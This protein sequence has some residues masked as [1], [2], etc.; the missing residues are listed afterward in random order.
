MTVL[1]PIVHTRHLFDRCPSMRTTCSMVTIVYHGRRHHHTSI[2]MLL[3]YSSAVIFRL[4]MNDVN[5]SWL[6][7]VSFNNEQLMCVYDCF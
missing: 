5:V 7:I 1:I 2:S 4:I 6:L 3:V